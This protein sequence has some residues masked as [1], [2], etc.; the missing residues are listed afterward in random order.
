[1]KLGLPSL[2]EKMGCGRITNVEPLPKD[3]LDRLY[4]DR[5][6]DLDSIRQLIAAQPKDAG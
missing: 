1:M 2:R 5:E 3:V 6:E 4:E